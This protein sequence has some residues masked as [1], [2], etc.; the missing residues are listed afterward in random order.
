MLL[1]I[2]KEVL[3]NWAMGFGLVAKVAQR[4]H[5]TGLNAD[6]EA[7]KRMVGCY[8]QFS[9]A[10]GKDILEI[11]PG[12]TLEVLGHALEEGARS[13][14][15]VDV[16]EYVPQE[17]ARQSGIDYRIYGGRELPFEA[18]QF[19]LIW[20]ST[21]F[22]HLRYPDVT[23]AECFRV[24][25]PG[26]LMIAQIDLGDH[27]FYPNPDPRRLFEGL[28]YPIWLWN[29][30]KWNRSSYVNRL[31]KSDWIRLVTSVG[32]RIKECQ[33]TESEEVRRLLRELAYLQT[34]SHDDAVTA[35]LLLCAEKPKI[36]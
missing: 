24:L 29:L 35:V 1:F 30:M 32:F 15:V 17:R 33:A 12:Q 14:S 4:F 10:A 6:R 5:S 22:E 11:G 18:A 2:L 31:R 9:S 13:C 20:S 16:V 36:R 27:S 25:R 8:T 3:Q 19:D 28:K 23:V 26:G 21:A 34:Y 7:A